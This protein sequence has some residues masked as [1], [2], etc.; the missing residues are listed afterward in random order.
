M[1]GALRLRPPSDDVPPPPAPPALNSAVQPPRRSARPPSRQGREERPGRASDR[2]RRRGDR[3]D[4]QLVRHCARRVRRRPAQRS[5]VYEA[6]EMY[7]SDSNVSTTR[8][9]HDEDGRGAAAPTTS[10]PCL[11][12]TPPPLCGPPSRSASLLLSPLPRSASPWRIWPIS[13]RRSRAGRRRWSEGSNGV[14]SKLGAGRLARAAK[15]GLRE[16]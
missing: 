2:D 16:E 4:A 1:M 15:E 9:A 3:E 8:E 7:E 11:P 14:R 13:F 12:T 10:S 6:D 5:V